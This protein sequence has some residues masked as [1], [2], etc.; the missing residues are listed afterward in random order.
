[1]TVR[2]YVSWQIHRN[3]LALVYLIYQSPESGVGEKGPL[4]KKE[5]Q[6]QVEQL[7]LPK[8]GKGKL[9]A[10][11]IA[12]PVLNNSMLISSLPFLG[13]QRG[14]DKEHWERR[15]CQ[16]RRRGRSLGPV[17]FVLQGKSYDAQNGQQLIGAPGIETAYQSLGCQPWRNDNFSVVCELQSLRGKK[18]KM[19]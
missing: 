19:K 3:Q 4:R 10:Q 11:A 1:M 16:V 13:E 12:V 6:K 17:L 18:R 7:K 15:A 2:N 14:K 5:S 9:F 8:K